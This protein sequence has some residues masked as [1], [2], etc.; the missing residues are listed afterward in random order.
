MASQNQSI[1]FLLPAELRNQIYYELLCSNT[2]SRK[3]LHE[4]SQQRTHAAQPVYP[5][6]LSTCQRIH[7]EAQGLLY[8]THT[9]HAHTSLLTSLPHLVSPLKP[10][11][12]ASTIAKISRWHLDIRL[13][14]D[15]QFTEAQATRAFSGAEYLEI[16]AWQSQFGGC[17]DSVLSLFKGIRGVKVARVTGCAE[18]ELARWLE[19]S[20]MMPLEKEEEEQARDVE[21]GG[22]AT[23][24]GGGCEEKMGGAEVPWLQQSGSGAW[25][26]G[27]IE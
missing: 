11:V 20:M 24:V 2:P 10:I 9:F 18:A 3:G 4:Y 25:N 13:D 5:A 14:T 22:C 21:M 16:H 8:S 19:E 17:D 6:I 26:F 1:L 15:P 12:N 23:S 27:N 7:Q